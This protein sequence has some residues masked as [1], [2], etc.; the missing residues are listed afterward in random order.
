M[1]GKEEREREDEESGL[2]EEEEGNNRLSQ[3]RENKK[4]SSSNISRL[5]EAIISSMG[6]PSPSFFSLSISCATV[7]NKC[8]MKMYR[9]TLRADSNAEERG[10]GRGEKEER[11][12]TEDEEDEESCLLFM[13][14]G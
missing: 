7:S 5:C 3:E 1:K 14:E 6:L 13:N 4:S 2:E 8:C 12:G 10:G 11:G 9:L